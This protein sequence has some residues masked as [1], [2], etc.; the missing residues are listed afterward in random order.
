MNMASIKTRVLA[1]YLAKVEK[2]NETEFNWH[3]RNALMDRGFR[4]L[5]IR[6]AHETGVA[7][8]LVYRQDVGST[9]P[10]RPKGQQV[11]EAWLELK[12]VDVISGWEREIRPAQRQFMREHWGMGH[13]AL[14]VVLCRKEGNV[15]IHQGDLKGGA[16]VVSCDLGL[17]DWNDLF[18]HFKKRR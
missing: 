7:D 17:I 15:R 14:F 18:Y 3:M 10:D 9:F 8:L 2:W 13:N 1:S 6:E 16:R 11:I 5:H 12:A 4:A